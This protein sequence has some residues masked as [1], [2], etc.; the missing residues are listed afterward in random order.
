MP[1]IIMGDANNDVILDTE[2]S[3]DQYIK[4][5]IDNKPNGYYLESE[6]FKIEILI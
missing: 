3:E 4:I 6:D 1:N 5:G 2:P